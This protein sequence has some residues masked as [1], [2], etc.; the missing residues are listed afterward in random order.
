MK[1]R[2][3]LARR[4]ATAFVNLF[5]DT[6]S[7]ETIKK[8]DALLVFLKHNTSAQLVLKLPSLSQAEQKRVLD[9]L[10]EHH[11]L[12]PMFTKLGD[13]LIRDVRVYLL[14]D[15]V[16]YIQQ[17]YAEHHGI[18]S[19]TIKS[20]HSLTD[21]QIARLV[22]FAEY[23]TGKKIIYDLHIDPKLIAGVALRGK[24]FFWEHSVRRQLD[25]LKE[26]LIRK[27]YYEQY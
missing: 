5:A 8:L 12:D 13:L 23:K 19:C 17:L 20:S 10:F 14:E 2:A 16:R 18:Y 24:T 25:C 11:G 1:N 7:K 22:E 4:Y 9:R 26:P 27:G 15:I 21:A 6:L 3:L